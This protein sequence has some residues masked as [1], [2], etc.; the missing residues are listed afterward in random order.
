MKNK[1]LITAGVLAALVSCK[2]G[3]SRFPGYDKTE[4]GAFF[5]MEK[6]G[7]GK[8]A[9]NTGDVIFIHHIMTTDKDSVL[10]DYKTM[11][12]QGQGP[13]AMRL[14][15]SVYKGD[16]FEMMYK[17]HVGDSASFAM[18]VD[19]M[20]EKYYKQPIP[21]FLS[22]D[23]FIVYHVMIDSMYTS[24]K[25]DEIEKKNRA[26]QDAYIESAKNSEDSLINKYL[27]DNKITVKPTESGLYLDVKIKGKGP[28]IKKGDVV[29]VNYKGMFMDGRIFDAS[30]RHDQAFFVP[31]GMQQVIPAW[32]EA[33]LSMSVGEKVLLVCPSKIAYGPNGYNGIPPYAPLVFEMEI[34]GIKSDK[35]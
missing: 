24:A 15:P 32:D 28:K 33:L 22:K 23:G 27:A 8:T 14:A 9:L 7:E 20:F 25:V 29:E 34:V 31:A 19:S 1:F 21:P 16:M 26:M 2:N 11:T 18:R 13:Y 5:K 35:K 3:D 4:S 6:A 30:D 17:L 12:R 10:Y